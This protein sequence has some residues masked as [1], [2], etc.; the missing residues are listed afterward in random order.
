M[1]EPKMS[2]RK[3]VSCLFVLTV[4][5]VLSSFAAVAYAQ[6]PFPTK[7]VR[8]IV[9]FP[10]GQA[11][12]IVARVLTG[13]LTKIWGQQV[14]VDNRAGGGG[15]PG[16]MAGR[17][18]PADGYTMTFG[19]SSTMSVNPNIYSDL[20]YRLQDFA[21]VNSV[22]ISPW[23]I[24]A[25]PSSPYTSLK[26]IVDAAKKEPGKLNVGSGATAFQLA[27]AA[28]SD[29]AG[30]NIVMVP[31]KG[32]GPAMIDLLGAHIPLLVDT[33]ASALPHIKEGKI[34]PIA[35]LSERRTSQL[36]N[37]PTVSELGY[38][39]FHGSGWGGIVVPKGT[40]TEVIEKIGGDLRRVLNDQTVQRR[41]TE[42]GVETDSRP[43]KEWTEFVNA[44]IAKWAEVV[45]RNPKGLVVN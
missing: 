31:Y 40:P 28:F 27:A 4:A 1:E 25:H 37:L 30:I 10:P 24:V 5:S 42:N 45:R 21:L 33:V 3:S 32:S 41:L 15:I 9:T 19:G 13:E 36:P 12:D 39:G 43:S 29:R 44:E 26:D 38:P 23:V 22:F 20:P 34:R 14:V 7:P 18:A 8:L 2:F 17:N 16:M 11:I 35:S 6:T